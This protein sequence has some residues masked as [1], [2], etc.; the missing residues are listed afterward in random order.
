MASRMRLKMGDG[1]VYLNR[2]GVEHDRIGGVFLHKME[3][4]DPGTWLHD[5]PWVFWRLILKGGYIERSA[6]IHDSP[7]H[8]PGGW[9]HA[10]GRWTW[11]K[12]DLDH[13]H[14]IAHLLKRTSWSLVIHGPKRMDREAGKLWGFYTPDGW[15][16]GTDYRNEDRE[17]W[18]DLI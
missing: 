1:A 7:R 11:S 17:I 8:R 10:V 6:H 12:V 13:C 16:P 2:W 14:T 9:S 18:N 5:H 4:P 3:A 15:T